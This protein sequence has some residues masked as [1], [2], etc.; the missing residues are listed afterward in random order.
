M[1]KTALLAA[2]RDVRFAGAFINNSGSTGTAISRRCFGERPIHMNTRFPHWCAPTYRQW[3]ERESDLPIDQHQLIACVAPRM[4][5]ISS[6]QQD[7]WA[8]PRGEFLGGLTAE[9]AFIDAGWPGLKRPNNQASAPTLAP[10]LVIT[11]DQANT[12]SLISIGI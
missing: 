12:I 3:H 10:A 8:D 5:Y 11:S 1:G 7:T 9:P 6:A 2:A 4:C